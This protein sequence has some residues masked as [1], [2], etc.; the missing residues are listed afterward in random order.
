MQKGKPT[1]NMFPVQISHEVPATAKKVNQLTG[2]QKLLRFKCSPLLFILS[3][4]SRELY[5][6]LIT[7]SSH[8]ETFTTGRVH[9]LRFC[10]AACFPQNVKAK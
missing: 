5:M 2:I 8:L 3:K 9:Q 10:V 7:K 6:S 4:N 1:F